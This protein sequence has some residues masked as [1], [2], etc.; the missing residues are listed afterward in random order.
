MKVE[1]ALSDEKSVSTHKTTWSSRAYILPWRYDIWRSAS[2]K[3]TNRL[4][5]FRGMS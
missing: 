4:M 3:K 5:L 2:I 1:V